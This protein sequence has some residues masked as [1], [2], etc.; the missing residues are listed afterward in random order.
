MA[1]EN[2]C[3]ADQ[4]A[5]IRVRQWHRRGRAD[6][7]VAEQLFFEVLGRDG[8]TA[9]AD[10][11]FDAPGDLQVAVVA[12]SDQ[13]AAAI[14]AGWIEAA[15]VVSVGAEVAVDGVGTAHQ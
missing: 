2:N 7:R 10:D 6:R 4:L 14:E 11:V 9:A 13:V 8:L 3:S 5:H 12:E 1:R 15:L